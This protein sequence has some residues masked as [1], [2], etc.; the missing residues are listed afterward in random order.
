LKSGIYNAY[1]YWVLLLLTKK[2]KYAIIICESKQC[3][4]TTQEIKIM[5]KAL[6]K[7]DDNISGDEMLIDGLKFSF[8]FS[9]FWVLS[10]SHKNK[11]TWV[12]VTVSDESH[13]FYSEYEIMTEVSNDD[14]KKNIIRRGHNCCPLTP[15]AL[16]NNVINGAKDNFFTEKNN[17]LKDAR[18]K[19]EQKI[20]NANSDLL[21]EDIFHK[22]ETCIPHYVNFTNGLDRNNLVLLFY[23]AFREIDPGWTEIVHSMQ[24]PNKIIGSLVY[25][26][27]EHQWVVKTQ[28][29]E[30]WNSYIENNEYCQWDEGSIRSDYDSSVDV[31]FSFTAPDYL[32]VI[33][34]G[35]EIIVKNNLSGEIFSVSNF[36]NGKMTL[37][38]LLKTQI[39]VSN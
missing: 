10:N 37:K 13:V 29:P 9:P 12:K 34:D 4:L 11:R 30:L 22:I 27:N 19:E 36:D 23:M 14:L 31:E 7:V 38:D 8:C 28:N 16:P 21:G 35:K 2:Y 1:F 33:N 25:Q 18:R 5:D 17:A 26:I 32:E 20:L 24:D 39:K 15:F 3:Y 6:F